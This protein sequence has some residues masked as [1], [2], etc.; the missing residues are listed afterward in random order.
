M[1]LYYFF[2]QTIL[3]PEVFSMCDVSFNMQKFEET[4]VAVAKTASVQKQQILF[5][6]E[7]TKFIDVQK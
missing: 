6:T 7:T 4:A 2:I 3:I 1:F 5:T